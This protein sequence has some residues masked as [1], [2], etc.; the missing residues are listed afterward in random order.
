MLSAASCCCILSTFAGLFPVAL[1]ISS[2]ILLLRSNCLGLPAVAFWQLSFGLSFRSCLDLPKPSFLRW[3]G[4]LAVAAEHTQLLCRTGVCPRSCFSCNLPQDIPV[5]A[6]SLGPFLRA[7]F[8]SAAASCLQFCDLGSEFCSRAIAMNL[9]RRRFLP[10]WNARPP[11][12]CR[13]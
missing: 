5:G 10:C 9:L 6:F 4:G 13:S 8:G 12:Y 7:C 11:E 3:R 1:D 2:K